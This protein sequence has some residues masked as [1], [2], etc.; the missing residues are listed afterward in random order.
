MSGTLQ[1]ILAATGLTEA[2]LA[3]LC[4]GGPLPPEREAALRRAIAAKPELASFFA[5]MRGDRATLRVLD[6]QVRAPAGI[7]EAVEIRL[8]QEALRTL[9]EPVQAGSIPVAATATVIERRNPLATFFERAWV[10]RLSAAA[11]LLAAIGS[12]VWGTYIGIKNW[13]TGGPGATRPSDTLARND[14]SPED[15]NTAPD[16]TNPFAQAE[17]F[18]AYA[19]Y[20]ALA[21]TTSIDGPGLAADGEAISEP[22][23]LELAGTGRLAVVVSGNTRS[24]SERLRRVAAA[25]GG[26]AVASDVMPG[27]AFSDSVASAVAIEPRA[28]ETPLLAA[29]YLRGVRGGGMLGSRQVMNL[30]TSTDP[31]QLRATLA[32]CGVLDA[33]RTPG[34]VVR[35]VVLDEPIDQPPATDAASVLWWSASPSKWSRRTVVPVIIEE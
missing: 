14:Q 20:S 17:A 31:A 24:V 34:R 16:P 25:G 9:T 29:Q 7:I 8:E 2:E 12:G 11:L 30:V 32:A 19:D 21:S 5:G 23:L 13:P 22:R 3:D 18:A 6:E 26:F 1:H 33:E 27:A 4:E 10:R 28:F 35:V 15:T